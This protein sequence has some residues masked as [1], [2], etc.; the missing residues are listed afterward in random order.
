M[1]YST[2]KQ[3]LTLAEVPK[4]TRTYKPVSHSQLI[5]LTLNSIEKA[6]F[7]IENELYSSANGGNVANGKFTIK[8]VADNEMSL[9]IA[10]QNSYD[11][12]MSLK[13][14][15]G[16]HVFI[17]SNGAVHGDMGSFKKKHNGTIQEFAPARITDY[18]KSA[19]DVFVQ[20]QKEKEAMKQIELSKRVKAE[21]IGRMFIEEQII[22]STQLNIISRELTAPTFDYNS[23]N[24]LWELYQFTTHSLKESHPSNWMSS[25]IKAHKFFV[26]ESGF[27]ISDT[28]PIFP[29]H[30]TMKIMHANGDSQEDVEMFRQL[31]L[32]I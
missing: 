27:L 20:M 21:L 29:L 31:S 26:N 13:F 25:H 18:I 9:Q 6:G 32:D 19:G 11:R 30:E 5:D 4:E 3:L 24:S 12:S 15:I 14:A 7:Q 16:V 17:C 23:E 2:T 22:T 1:S 8:N 10:W 28:E